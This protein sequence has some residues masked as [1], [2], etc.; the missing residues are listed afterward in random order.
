M[1]RIV[2]ELILPLT[3]L[4]TVGLCV[5]LLALTCAHAATIPANPT[6]LTARAGPG[7]TLTWDMGWDRAAGYGAD[8][9]SVNIWRMDAAGN[10]S[11]WR[12]G[13]LPR[14]IG[15]YIASGRYGCLDKV[16]FAP[17]MCGPEDHWHCVYQTY[18]TGGDPSK[19]F[20]Y[21]I[22]VCDQGGCSPAP[23]RQPVW[24]PNLRCVDVGI[25]DG[26]DP[27]TRPV[28]VP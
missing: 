24:E 16:T 7:R 3:A 17:K 5:V 25:V 14:N 4:V 22:Y 19:D 26:C 8:S 27:G 13:Q 21:G 12:N 6:F 18:A 23:P 20:L 15:C 10:Q 11:A 2:R 9:V 1:K 28:A